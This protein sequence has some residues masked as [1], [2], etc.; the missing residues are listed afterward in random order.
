MYP[1][2]G[3]TYRNLVF[4]NYKEVTNLRTFCYF[5]RLI[6]IDTWAWIFPLDV[7]TYKDLINSDIHSFTALI[8][9][10]IAIHR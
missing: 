6:R 7:G 2:K 10:P 8:V 5:N 3:D 9:F 1:D 4:Y